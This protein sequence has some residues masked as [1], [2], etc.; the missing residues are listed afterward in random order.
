MAFSDDVNPTDRAVA[1]SL[2]YTCPD[3]DQ[4]APDPDE[5][6]GAAGRNREW[7]GWERELAAA[8]LPMQDEI[9]LR[10][11]ALRALD[12]VRYET[13][14]RLNPKDKDAL[15]HKVQLSSF[16]SSAIIGGAQACQEGASNHGPYN[17]RT[18]PKLR[19]TVYLD[20]LMRHL[21]ALRDGEN[22]DGVV[23]DFT[24][25]RSVLNSAEM[26]AAL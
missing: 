19:Y 14:H 1:N 17:W 20:A 11:A 5:A 6:S 9:Q 21:L 7:G 22:I 10:Q 24:I 8:M 26:A 13:E 18:G 3:L 25:L 16:P 23:E 4:S 15:A 2:P 12:P